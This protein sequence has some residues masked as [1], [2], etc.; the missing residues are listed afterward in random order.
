[1]KTSGHDYGL[2][3]SLPSALT[4][5]VTPATVSSQLVHTT[6][7]PGTDTPFLPYTVS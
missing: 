6:S 3:M 5:P 7:D 2:I 1:M 4:T